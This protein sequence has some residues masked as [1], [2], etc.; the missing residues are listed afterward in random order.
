MYGMDRD[1]HFDAMLASS[2]F[3][4]PKT[5][6][7]ENLGD[8]KVRLRADDKDDSSIWRYTQRSVADGTTLRLGG[9]PAAQCLVRPFERLPPLETPS[10]II[11]SNQF[12]Q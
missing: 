7:A 11:D 9:L 12:A 2:P 3:R 8:G 1:R 4:Q 5:V 10:R 6:L